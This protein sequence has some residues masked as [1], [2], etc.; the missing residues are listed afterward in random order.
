MLKT[1]I[2]CFRI[3]LLASGHHRNRVSSI[4]NDFNF[5]RFCEIWQYIVLYYNIMIY[6]DRD[7]P[8]GGELR[9][10]SLSRR[11]QGFG[12]R[13]GV[14]N[15]SRGLRVLGRRLGVSNLSRRQ[16]VLAEQFLNIDLLIF[17]F[18]TL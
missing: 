11:L 17:T 18:T 2:T 1:F 4:I 15:L 12:R 8:E 6:L 9:V 5:I 16:G 7:I 10:L 13:L 3:A 14:S